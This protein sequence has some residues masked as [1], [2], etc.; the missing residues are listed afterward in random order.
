VA[1]GLTGGRPRAAGSHGVKPIPR[2][3]PRLLP[4]PALAIV[5]GVRRNAEPTYAVQMVAPFWKALR[6][7]PQIPGAVVDK[8]EATGDDRRMPVAVAQEALRA[9]VELTGDP[10]VGLRAARA[11]EIG[12][13]KVLEYVSASAPTWRAGIET[14][15]RYSH[16]MNEAADFRLEIA[17]DKAHLILHSTVPLVRAGVD[18]QSAAFHVAVSRWLDSVPDEREV[19]FSHPRP[20]NVREYE[21]TFAP[22][23]LVF[24][25]PWNGFV[26][27]AVRLDTKLA[28]HDPNVHRV[29]REQAD[30][31]LA[32]LGP[33]EN[34]IE[35]VRAH[36]L[37]SLREGPPSAAETAAR[38]RITRR[39]LT[40]KLQHEGTSFTVLLD[41]VR[42]RS[43]CHYLENT[44][45]SVEDI[46]F[47]IGFSEAS[48][49]VR[50]FKRWTG[51]APMAYRRAQ[52]RA[53]AQSP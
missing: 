28:G 20:E 43:A 48:P 15:F 7:Y 35:R 50:A 1:A 25:A 41:E 53:A 51:I 5:G 46:A 30:R 24:G 18:F 9:L 3:S 13:F 49:F 8:L 40:R 17:G 37:S 16:L 26:M 33:G 31:L 34:L 23:K 21:I 42:K 22:S 12:S 29:L 19:W 32:E 11:T 39:T 52:R 4:Q 6:S 27:N 10:D 14:V 47:L 44:E 36:I 38:M 2:P 45:H